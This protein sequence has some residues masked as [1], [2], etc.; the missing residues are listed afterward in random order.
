MR[1]FIIGDIHGGYRGL[2]QVLEL[3]SIM[4]TIL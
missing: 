2:L 3:I 4:K 1:K